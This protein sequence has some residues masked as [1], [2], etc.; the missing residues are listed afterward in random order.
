MKITGSKQRMCFWAWF[1]AAFFLGG[2]NIY[3][4]MS[5]AQEPLKG[6]PQIIRVLRTKLQQF[7]SMSV[8]NIP[9][10]ET[11]T[12]ENNRPEPA[13]QKT[14]PFVPQAPDPIVW[15]VLSG[16]MQVVGPDGSIS[17]LAVIDGQICRDND[18]VNQFT[19]EQIAP[20]GVV[21]DRSGQ[22]HF[23][24]SPVP[25]YSSDQGE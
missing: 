12:S 7:E 25:Y 1:L 3:P 4:F 8:L 14:A 17:F 16:I 9:F 15:P 21:L 20:A 2:L 24:K 10:S 23:I 22:K 11:I 5:L 18:T 6:Y 13:L 19:V